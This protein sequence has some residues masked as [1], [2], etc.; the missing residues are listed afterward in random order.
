M[1][2]AFYRP[3][4]GRSS[5][6]SYLFIRCMDVLIQK[7]AVVSRLPKSAIGFKISPRGSTIPCLMFAGDSLVFCKSTT[8]TCTKLK[9]ILDEF[10]SMSGQMINFLKSTLVLSK[11]ILNA[12]KAS[13]GGFFNMPPKACLGRYLGI[14]FSSYYPQK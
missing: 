9:N 4:A 2:Q 11:Q 10:C 13:L 6:S 8:T 1:V 12:R 5:L 14:F 3:Q 7:L